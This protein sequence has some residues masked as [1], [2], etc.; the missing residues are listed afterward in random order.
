M[1]RASFFLE[2]KVATSRWDVAQRPTEPAGE[3]QRT[4]TSRG[5][6]PSLAWRRPR[7]RQP[8][9]EPGSGPGLSRAISPACCRAV[10]AAGRSSLAGL[11]QAAARAVAKRAWLRARA[12][13]R[14]FSRLLPCRFRRGALV[15]RWPGAGRGP[16]SR[17]G[18]LAQGPGF[19]ALFLPPAAV[20]FRRG[21]P[22]TSA[23]PAARAAPAYPRTACGGR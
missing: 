12:F 8:R 19:L 7:P 22:P 20:P 21:A 10:F 2:R 15:P 23:A 14:Y 18:S 6:R 16:G 3:T 9:R 11:A 17:E 5:A 13:S 4:F 1:G